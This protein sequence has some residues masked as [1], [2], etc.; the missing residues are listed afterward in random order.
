LALIPPGVPANEAAR[1][2]YEAPLAVLS[3]GDGPDPRFTYANRTALG[4]FEAG[5]EELLAMPSRLSAEPLAR[6]ERARLL[7]AV[8]E[9]GFIDDYA[10]VRISRRGRR[11]RI[12]RATVWTVRGPAGRAVG[13]AAMFSRWVPLG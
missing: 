13:Q 1:W 9:R 7:A 8:A 12:E 4:L 2:V 11:F 5:W 6:E 10:G 3:H